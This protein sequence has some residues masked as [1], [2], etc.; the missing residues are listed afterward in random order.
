MTSPNDRSLEALQHKLGCVTK[1]LRRHWRDQLQ[2]PNMWLSMEKFRKLLRHA[3]RSMPASLRLLSLTRR[4]HIPGMAAA[5][6]P[7]FGCSER[8]VQA[9]YAQF[10]LEAAFLSV[11]PILEE[12]LFTDF[13]DAFAARHTEA[14][15]QLLQDLCQVRPAERAEHAEKWL[16][17]FLA[18]S[19][20]AL[21]RALFTLFHY[22]NDSDPSAW[23]P[24]AEDVKRHLGPVY[25]TV[26]RCLSC[27][28]RLNC[29]PPG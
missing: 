2:T 21:Y 29:R 12:I 26:Q 9:A 14:Y 19:R 4:K 5:L 13:N 24:Q 23:V 11:D 7:V 15:R 8:Q 18:I 6:A 20:K 17:C 28:K 22:D 16:S 27:A 25:R 3:R 1:V 10:V